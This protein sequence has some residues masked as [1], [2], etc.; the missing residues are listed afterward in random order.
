MTLTKNKLKIKKDWFRSSVKTDYNEVKTIYISCRS[1]SER[2]TTH[3]MFLCSANICFI[4]IST[5]LSKL[6]LRSLIY[7]PL[8][9]GESHQRSESFNH[10]IP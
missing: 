8:K 10:Q 9:T 4:S 6:L 3:G 7:S 5:P 2:Y 1:A